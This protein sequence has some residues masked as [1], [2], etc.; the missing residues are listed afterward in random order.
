M[1]LYDRIFGSDLFVSIPAAPAGD[2]V[3]MGGKG[4][5]RPI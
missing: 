4:H 2:V 3:L 1:V 5:D